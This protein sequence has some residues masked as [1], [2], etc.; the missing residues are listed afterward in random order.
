VDSALSDIVTLPVWHM[1]GLRLD[2]STRTYDTGFGYRTERPTF[3]RLT[4]VVD[5]WRGGSWMQLEKFTGF[6]VALILTGLA[7]LVPPTE[8]G[9]RV[10]IMTSSIFAAVFNRYRL[11]D[12]IGFDTSFGLVDQVSMLTFSAI[13]TMLLVSLYT[14]NQSRSRPAALVVPLDRRLGGAVLGAHWLMV[15]LAFLLVLA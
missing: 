12:R 11:E 1:D 6:L 9:T 15:A 13:L 4:L 5:I 14:H 3:S 8:L 7:L 10:G 2:Q